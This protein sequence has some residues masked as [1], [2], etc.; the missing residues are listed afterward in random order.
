MIKIKN[1]HY[2]YNKHFVF[3]NDQEKARIVIIEFEIS[4]NVYCSFVDSSILK[5]HCARKWYA[6]ICYMI[7]EMQE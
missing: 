5:C 7:R 1:F 6:F 4:I 2:L 3:K